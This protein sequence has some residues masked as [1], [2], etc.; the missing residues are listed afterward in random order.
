MVID[1]L[2][3]GQLIDPRGAQPLADEFQRM[4]GPP[5]TE[6]E[7]LLVAAAM[8]LSSADGDPGGTA[9]GAADAILEHRPAGE[10]I[11]ARLAA[12]LI[13]VAL[14]RRTGEHAAAADAAARAEHLL[15]EI[16]EALLARHPGVRVEV[17]S[18][19][20]A[21]ELW[22]GDF[23]KAADSLKAGIAAAA[24]GSTYERAGCL[25]NLAL[26]EA[27]RGKLTRASELA[28]EAAGDHHDQPADPATPAAAVALACVRLA[29]GD[30]REVRAQLK[31][32]EAALR[33]RPDRLTG[34]LACAVA[35][36]RALAEGHGKIETIRAAKTMP[37][38]LL[39]ST[40]TQ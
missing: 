36:R 27:L 17:L 33:L 35:A 18:G 12:A 40:T 30:L 26:V 2:A 16:P 38:R 13:R 28:D 11:P 23:D 7:P 9:L 39:A 22:A 29:R 21:V 32:A 34:V 14:S 31:L 8:E 15:E 1:A 19:R 5:G 37:R 24:P 20:G 6:P 25:G 4:P 3:I 10:D